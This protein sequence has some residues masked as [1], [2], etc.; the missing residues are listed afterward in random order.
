MKNQLVA[1]LLVVL[2]LGTGCQPPGVAANSTSPP[3]ATVQT[4]A[5]RKGEIVRE[6]TLPGNVRP[7]QEVTLYAKVAGYLK[8]ISVDQGDWV[9]ADA[10]LAEIEAPEMLADL[11][12]LKAEQARLQAEAEK[13]RAE[14]ELARIDHDR[15][16]AAQAKSSDLV[17]PLAVD[18]ADAQQKVAQAAL[19]VVLAQQAE[20]SASLKRLET[21]L[22]YARITAPFDGV[23]TRRWV[24]PGAFIPA[25]TSS[26][27][28][29][30]AAIVTIMD[31]RRVRVTVALPDTEAP[32]ATTNLPVKVT[33]PQLPGRMFEGKITRFAYALDEATKTMP[34]E[35]EIPNPNL[36]LRP[37][38]YASVQIALQRRTDAL[39]VP[40]EAL[41]SEKKKS[42]LFALRDGKAVR[43][44]VRVGF[45][46]G[47]RAEIL[48]GVSPGER[49]IV[50]GKQSLAD[51][52]P[53]QGVEAK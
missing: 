26:T 52:Q 40:A 42:Y 11:D 48:E 31:F 23:I 14:A 25:A 17:L 10:L 41:V 9:K 24:D 35:I 33:V 13:R 29:R 39:L 50:A 15:L 20:T 3:P 7:W 53:V 51:G 44:P 5:V 47:V 28:A 37:G 30:S 2:A 46:D 32:L 6:L 43:L 27:A 22:A 49:V 16:Q 8:S 1:F 12:K 45:D 18:K 38:M 4:V 19:S 21:L 36:T 34:V